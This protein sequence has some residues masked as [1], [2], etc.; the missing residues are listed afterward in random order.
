M[1]HSEERIEA[2][3][4]A[5]TAGANFH[6]TGGEVLNSDDVFVAKEKKIRTAKIA[7]LLRKKL[8]ADKHVKLSQDYTKTL[9]EIDVRI[10][11]WKGAASEIGKLKNEPLKKLVAYY[12]LGEKV[13]TTKK[14]LVKSWLENRGEEGDGPAG[15]VDFTIEDHAE[16]KKLQEDKISVDET[17]FK[18]EKRRKI[19]EAKAMILSIT[20]NDEHTMEISDFVTNMHRTMVS[21]E[22]Q[23]TLNMNG[24][25]SIGGPSNNNDGGE[26]S[27][28]AAVAVRL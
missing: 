8:T 28:G 22:T 9:G 13:P 1:A 10:D 7:D 25:D 17:M 4:K 6:A 2:L 24:I 5:S 3:Q 12:L 18:K 11:L 23:R 16:L 19:D 27:N 26:D 14:P 15:F 20:P 21:T